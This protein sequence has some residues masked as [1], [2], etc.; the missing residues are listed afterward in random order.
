[1][2]WNLSPLQSSKFTFEYLLLPPRSALESVPV[3]L[4]GW[5][6]RHKLHALLL[7]RTF[8]NILPPSSS[9]SSYKQKKEKEK[10]KKKFVLSV[11]YR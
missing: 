2:T 1:L 8:V 10:K 3:T 4:T 9:S 6:L 7:E 5:N 11:E